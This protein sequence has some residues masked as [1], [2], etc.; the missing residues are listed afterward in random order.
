[1][2]KDKMSQTKEESTE[3][4]FHF[5]LD[6]QEKEQEGGTPFISEMAASM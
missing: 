2:T 1:M 5:F 4:G 6:V 3:N